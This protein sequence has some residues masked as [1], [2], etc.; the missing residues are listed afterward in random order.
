MNKKLK[1]QYP[2]IYEMISKH[3][4][5]LEKRKMAEFERCLKETASS[6]FRVDRHA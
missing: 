2:H 4:A 5:E 6:V 3:I 1:Q